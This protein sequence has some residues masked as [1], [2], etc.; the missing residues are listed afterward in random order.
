MLNGLLVSIS[1][2]SLIGLPLW[3]CVLQFP[4]RSGLY[5]HHL[6]DIVHSTVRTFFIPLILYSFQAKDSPCSRTLYQVTPLHYSTRI[7]KP[8]LLDIKFLHF[9][10]FEKNS[11][12]WGKREKEIERGICVHLLLLNLLGSGIRKIC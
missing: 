4:K 11:R 8:V 6:H 2:P 10:C 7:P 12:G 9:H 3:L 1:S 5:C